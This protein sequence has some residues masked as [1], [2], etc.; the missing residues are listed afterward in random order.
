M[1]THMHESYS[2]FFMF[3]T[4]LQVDWDDQHTDAV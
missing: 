4:D 3:P 2:V 1:V